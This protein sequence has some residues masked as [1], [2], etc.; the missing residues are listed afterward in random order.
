MENEDPLAWWQH[1]HGASSHFPI[2]LLL[3]AFLVDLGAT[4]LRRE[5]WRLISFFCLIVGTLGLIP[6]L[7]SG[8]AGGNG[9]FGVVWA[10]AAYSEKMPQHRQI[11]LIASALAFVV[12]FWRVIRRE[13][14]RGGE[15]AMYLVALF[16]TCALIGYTGFLGGYV[17]HGY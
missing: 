5:Q 3:V 13:R 10:N 17:G 4:I 1:M 8:L 6:S 2:A 14:L 12:M 16:I 15:W 7:I 11:A 9:W